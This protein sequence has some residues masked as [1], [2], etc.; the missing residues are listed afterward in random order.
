MCKTKFK[1]QMKQKL[2]L[3]ICCLSAVAVIY[4]SCD[5]DNDD[6]F[7]PPRDPNKPT[8]CTSFYPEVGGMATQVILAGENFGND[9]KA[10]EV[11]FND[12]PAPVIGCS[13][14]R[15][16]V[17]TPRRPGEECTISVKIGKDSVAFAQKYQYEIRAVVSTVVGKKGTTEYIAGS[18][19]DAQFR[20]PCYI[21][22]DSLGNIFIVEQDQHRVSMAN[23]NDKSVRTLLDLPHKGNAPST[24]I[25]G[26][27]I[28]VPADGNNASWNES[29]WE[30]N[31]EDGYIAKTR[32]ITKPTQA[33][34]AEGKQT[35]TLTAYKHSFAVCAYDS[36]V[37]YRSNQ[38]GIIIRFNPY[39]KEGE[40][41]LAYDT[42]EPIDCMLGTNGDGFLVNDPFEPSRMYVS[43]SGGGGRRHIIAYFDVR[44]GENGIYA[45]TDGSDNFGWV[46]G[47]VANA[48]FH[49][50]KQILLDADGNMLVA[51]AENHCIRQ[52]DLKDGI[53]STLVGIAG[54]AD[55]VDGNKDDACFNEPWGLAID[56]RDGTVYICDRLNKV[57]RMLSIE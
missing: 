38:N 9:P 22:I 1:N 6:D 42:G 57:I 49:S 23:M 56:R 28:V 4:H 30:F 53:V 40:R 25:T 10:I 32:T 2:F 31:S 50:P 7:G 47:P 12:K 24:D 33:D 37:Y 48:K 43:L 20:N 3:A 34:I 35:F 11:L 46:D 51:D 52:I 45:G 13:N 55:L 16:L 26:K 17:V 21:T 29:Y 41:A 39:T 36:M 27:L 44:T 14:K 18:F 19:A 8:I 5:N 54:K 15:I